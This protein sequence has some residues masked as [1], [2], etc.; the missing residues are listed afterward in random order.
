MGGVETQREGNDFMDVVDT[1]DRIALITQLLHEAAMLVW[2]AADGAAP[3]SVLHDLGLGVYLAHNHAS[4]LLPVDYKFG[5][6][7]PAAARERTPLQLIAEA[8]A[9]AKQLASQQPDLLQGAP[10]VVDLR[11]LVQEARSLGY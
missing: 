7:S 8:E 11:D 10:L 9:W 3:E 4:A 2:R 5:G 6:P 1:H